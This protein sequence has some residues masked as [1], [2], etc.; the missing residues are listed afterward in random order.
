MFMHENKTRL[1]PI[2]VNQYEVKQMQLINQT[3]LSFIH[4]MQTIPIIRIPSY[5]II[6]GS[7]WSLAISFYELGKALADYTVRV[8]DRI[9]QCL[10]A[11]IHIYYRSVIESVAL[12]LIYSAQMCDNIN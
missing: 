8:T 10:I 5:R 3:L 1:I 4:F 6:T 7:R 11:V 12:T 2:F 9:S